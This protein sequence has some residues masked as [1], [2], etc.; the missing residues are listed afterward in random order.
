M[1]PDKRQPADGRNPLFE[2]LGVLREA[3][4]LTNETGIAAI[5]A[6]DPECGVSDDTLR[7]FMNAG[8]EWAGRIR[9][10][11]EPISAI[12]ADVYAGWQA[13]EDVYPGERIWDKSR[14]FIAGTLIGAGHIAES[15]AFMSQIRDVRLLHDDI[16]SMGNHMT[17]NPDAI[18]KVT[19]MH[20]ILVTKELQ[21][22]MPDKH[23]QLLRH[24]RNQLLD[25]ANPNDLDPAGFTELQNEIADLTEGDFDPIDDW[26][27]L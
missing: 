2:I 10:G 12:M 25:V 8:T 27:A 19:E 14:K 21:R 23:L 24:T 20:V 16:F 1:S 9:A 4:V 13:M 3:G 5:R 15:A 7:A 22:N 17:G 11:D 6:E 18:R 26:A